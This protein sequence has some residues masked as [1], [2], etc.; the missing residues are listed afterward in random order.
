MVVQKGL[1][2]VFSG[3]DRVESELVEVVLGAYREGAFPMAEGRDAA[4]RG[5]PIGWYRPDPRAVLPIQPE[6]VGQTE[7]VHLPR[8]LMR[9][10]RAGKFEVTTDQA[11]AEVIRGCALPRRDTESCSSETWIDDRIAAAFGILHEA[12]HAHS[13]ETWTT[14]NE[15]RRT[16]VGGVYGLAIG[17]VF[18]AESMFCL[19]ELGGRDA[20]KV[21]LVH[22][23]QHCQRLGFSVIDTQFTNPHIQQ[24]GVI[25][26]PLDHYLELLERLRDEPISWRPIPEV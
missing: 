23:I 26:I 9:T 14:D 3:M 4:E 15:N 25:E 2:T 8:R 6:L 19:P 17:G 22:L 7:G 18:C 20:S 16:L 10:V 11:F 12:G 24:F 13:I 1:E 5:S 21:A